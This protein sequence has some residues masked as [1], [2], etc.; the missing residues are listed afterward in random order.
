MPRKSRRNSLRS[1][2]TESKV[3]VDTS[4]ENH[5]TSEA[6]SPEVDQRAK[7]LLNNVI[8]AINIE[9]TNFE[10]MTATI[11]NDQGFQNGTYEAVDK[12]VQFHKVFSEDQRLNG[13][14]GLSEKEQ[15]NL[16]VPANMIE[17]NGESLANCS[18]GNE[19]AAKLDNPSA[20]DSS[21]SKDD[22][23][24]TKSVMNGIVALDQKSS[25]HS[26]EVLNACSNGTS[27]IAIECNLNNC[28]SNSQSTQHEQV[29]EITVLQENLKNRLTEIARLKEENE[30]LRNANC[31]TIPLTETTVEI[32]EVQMAALEKT[33]T[34]LQKEVDHY[35]DKMT[36]QDE[37]T[38]S[39]ISSLRRD[40]TTKLDQMTKLYEA[41]EKDK[42]SMVVKYAL[43]EKSVLTIKKCLEETERKYKESLREKETLM[44][45]VRALTNDKARLNQ[46]IDAKTSEISFLQ[47]DAERVKEEIT[48]RDIKIKWAQ[49]KLKTEMDA[50]KETQGK[51]ERL[52]QKLKEAREESDQ[53]RKDCQEMIRTYQESEEI[54]SNSLDLQLKEKE[55][56]LELERQEKCDQEEVYVV[57]KKELEGLKKK[58]KIS[59]EENNALTRK[60]QNLERERLEYEKN[61]SRLKEHLS[62]GQQ[63]LVDLH[64]KLAEAQNLSAQ[65]ER[66]KDKVAS[67]WSEIE[68]LR[69]A[70]AELQIDMEACRRKEG[71]LLEFTERLTSKNV[72]LVSEFNCLEAKYN[73]T[74][75]ELTS[76]RKKVEELSS[77]CSN[78]ESLLNEEQQ[79]RKL[80]TQLLAR[81]LAEKTKIAELLNIKV[82]EQNNE[83]Q[84]LKKKNAFTI[85]ELTREVQALR[86]R[87]ETYEGIRNGQS[88]GHNLGSR[89]SS[90]GSLDKLGFA[91]CGYQGGSSTSKMNLQVDLA[92]AQE[93]KVLAN[94]I[95]IPLEPSRQVLIERIVKL[96]WSLARRNEKIEFLEEHVSQL[97]QE[98]QRK[99]KLIQNYVMREDAGALATNSMDLNKDLRS[100][101]ELAKKGGIMSSLYLSQANDDGMTLELSLEIC[102]KLQAV[103]EDTLLKNITLKENIKILGEE[104]ERLTRDHQHLR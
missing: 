53:L 61:L 91:S 75:R 98:I 14:H 63:E 50:H 24:L 69:Q 34:Q 58:H 47:R 9:D 88:D 94:S 71:E 35:R 101:V 68:R 28:S 42:E 6:I 84:V 76:L 77:T 59:V 79:Q 102:Q 16:L 96:Q 11:A 104:I 95:E 81:K 62:G 44:G 100:K 5:Q 73:E 54:K 1:K 80:E 48:S 97:L 57:M 60:V 18:T 67:S 25:N 83:N 55:S 15:L 17:E 86:R 4:S 21:K 85:R 7:E 82:E 56:E 12:D 23:D 70:N 64:A 92:A 22:S 90:T 74:G 41:S 46:T 87:L 8:D 37:F 10:G 103:L 89:T 19:E 40:L 65:I 20:S 66:E 2:V 13:E 99:S 51:L 43:S 30:R 29:N 93:S 52:E 39:T 72:C 78:L 3:A 31:E 27:E 36:D 49:N 26:T 45:K 32:Y 38:R 33:I